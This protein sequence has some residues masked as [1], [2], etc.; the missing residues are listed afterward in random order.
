[1]AS[2]V[3]HLAKNSAQAATTVFRSSSGSSAGARSSTRALRRGPSTR[4]PEATSEMSE[5][6]LPRLAQDSARAISAH[7]FSSATASPR[8]NGRGSNLE[9]GSSSATERIQSPGGISS[10]I[11]VTETHRRS[12]RRRSSHVGRGR[13][14]SVPTTTGPLDI[15]TKHHY[16]SGIRATLAWACLFGRQLRSPSL[17]EPYRRVT[18]TSFPAPAAIP[19]PG[20]SPPPPAPTPRTHPRRARRAPTTGSSGPWRCPRRG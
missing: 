19:P 16:R 13:P 3:L 4:S 15:L 20:C 2:G 17:E 11:V 9:T 1:M 12:P 14:A 7:S 18:L 5:S 6:R 10:A 8:V